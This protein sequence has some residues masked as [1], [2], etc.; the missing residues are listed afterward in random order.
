MAFGFGRQESISNFPPVKKPQA[1][2]HKF[3]KPKNTLRH[4]IIQTT[5]LLS[6]VV[7]ALTTLTA[8]G[9]KLVSLDS[10]KVSRDTELNFSK[11]D[12]RGIE[13]ETKIV[14]FVEKDMQMLTAYENGQVKWQVNII[15]TL[16]KPAV[17]QPAIRYIKLDKDKI[18]VTFGKHNYASVDSS[19]GKV[20]DLG[21]D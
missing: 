13:T 10:T 15:K 16:G 8:S 9:Q 2:S 19:T 6:T 12:K 20:T 1:V 18:F 5:I 3:Q 21:A 17:G 4:F 7:L 11:T 14:Y